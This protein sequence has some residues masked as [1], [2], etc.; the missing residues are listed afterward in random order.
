[1]TAVER[2]RELGAEYGKA[3]AEAWLGDAL[4]RALIRQRGMGPEPDRGTLFNHH[5]A[6]FRQQFVDREPHEVVDAYSDAFRAARDEIIR[7][8]V[9]S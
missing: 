4:G 6:E 1:M 3:A 7:E 9:Q 2:A 8:A 5:Y